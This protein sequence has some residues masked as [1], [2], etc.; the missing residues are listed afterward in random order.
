MNTQLSYA[1]TIKSNKSEFCCFFGFIFADTNSLQIQHWNFC[2]FKSQTKLLRPIV[3]VWLFFCSKI[4]VHTLYFSWMNWKVFSKL[5]MISVLLKDFPM[6]TD[7]SC[8]F[9]LPMIKAWMKTVLTRS[10][11]E[12]N[13]LIS[14]CLSWRLWMWLFRAESSFHGVSQHDKSTKSIN[15]LHNQF[16]HSLVQLWLNRHD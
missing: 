11:S 14:A 1:L 12:S 9:I 6:M 3:H 16:C 7:L 4:T 13:L 15:T 5:E 10:N 8:S 2:H